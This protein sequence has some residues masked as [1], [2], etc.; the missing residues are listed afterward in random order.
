MKVQ[1]QSQNLE[2]SAT[3]NVTL[4]PA[5]NPMTTYK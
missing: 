5:W 3:Q 2:I 4:L 1:Q